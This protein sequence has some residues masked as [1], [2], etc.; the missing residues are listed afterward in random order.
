[1]ESV[2]SGLS[3]GL[4]TLT[5]TLE[6][7]R[8]VAVDTRLPE[9]VGTSVRGLVAEVPKLPDVSS[10]VADLHAPD[11]HVR[12]ATRQIRTDGLR[13]PGV[14]LPEVRID[15]SGLRALGRRAGSARDFVGTLP[16]YR[17]RRET[18]SASTGA[19]L[20]AVLA[21]MIGGLWLSTW[22]ITAPRVH[23]FF[24]ALRSRLGLGDGW[25]ANSA[26]DALHRIDGRQGSWREGPLPRRRRRNA[27]LAGEPGG[28]GGLAGVA[29]GPGHLEGADLGVPASGGTD[30]GG[31][32]LGGAGHAATTYGRMAGDTASSVSAATRSP[33]EPG[34]DAGGTEQGAHREAGSPGTPGYSVPG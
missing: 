13:V 1:M 12:D 25:S 9:A 29:V 27:M 5:D 17:I 20:G 30:L 11:L 32:D 2:R 14:G 33:G 3:Q 18:R 34:A 16:E 19:I 26:R 31:A 4:R 22:P 23:A 15:A 8:D 21:G 7:V 6:D 10:L 28:R 24:E